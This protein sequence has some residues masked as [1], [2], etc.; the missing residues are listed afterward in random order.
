MSPSPEAHWEMKR[1]RKPIAPRDVQDAIVAIL[2]AIACAFA[3]GMWVGEVQAKK[4]TCKVE[5]KR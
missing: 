5:A 1:E 2:T 4:Q 3:I